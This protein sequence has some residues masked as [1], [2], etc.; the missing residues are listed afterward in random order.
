M[1]E[2]NANQYKNTLNL[3][4]TD[5]PMRG[6]LAKREPTM[7][8]Q[9][10]QL[11]LYGKL[12]KDRQDS[13]M[14][15]L[16]DGPPY[17]NGNIHIGHVV[18]KVIK[19]IIVKSRSMEGYNA[20]YVPGWDCHGLPIEHKVEQTLGKAGIDVEPA[21]F[22]KACREYAAGQID[23]QRDGFMR[24][25]IIGDWKHPYITMDYKIE[26]DI[27]R[28]LGRI[29]KQGHL[30][31]GE[32]PV[33]WCVDCGSALAEAEVEYED[34]SSPAIDVLFRIK[35]LKKLHE[36]CHTISETIENNVSI[37]IWTTTPWTLPA[38][39]AVAINPDFEYVFA[40]IEKEDQVQ[41]IIIAKDLLEPTL[42]RW[43]A[44]FRSILTQ[45]S[46]KQLEGLELSHP[47]LDRTV[48][49][50]L[51]DHVT[52]DT[53]TGAVH[54]AP[55][56]GLEDYLVGLRYGLS[57]KHSVGPDGHFL[58]DT[59]LF[60]G[61]QVFEANQHIIDI[62]KQRK[63]LM[64]ATTLQHSYPVCWRHKTPLIFRATPQWFISM[65]KHHLRD[66]ALSALETIQ[67]TPAWGKERLKGMILNRPDWCISRQR[68]WGVPLALFTHRKTGELHP[69]TETLIEKIA[70]RV[71]EQGVEAWFSLNPKELL[72]DDAD[73]YE[74]VTHILDVWFDS[75]TT[76]FSVLMRR[77]DLRFPADLYLEGSDQHRG[78]FQSSLLA[79]IGIN[80]S[81]PYK[82]VLTHGF[83]VDA[84]GRKMA[85]SLGN[86]IP[87]EK[88]INQLGADTIRLWVSSTDYRR[89]MTVS[90]QILKR[91]SEAY[92][93][94]RYTARYLLSNLHDF[95]PA[96]DLLA[97]DELLA[98]D[99][100]IIH[101]A[102]QLQDTIR[103]AYQRY[104]FHIIYQRIHNFCAVDLG[105]TYL[106]IIRDRQY[107]TQQNSR[108]R[109]SAQTAVYYITEALSRWLA[110]ILSFTADEIW[111]HIPG[112]RKESV[113]LEQWY[114]FPDQIQKGT[115][116]KEGMDTSFWTH[117]F[118][119]RQLVNRELEILR[120]E[121]RIG[122][123]LDAEVHLKTNGSTAHLLNLLQNELRFVLIT[124]EAKVVSDLSEGTEYTLEN[125][126]KIQIFAYPSSAEKCVRCWHHRADVGVNVNHPHLCG[127]CIDNIEG[128]GED[129][130]FA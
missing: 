14:F 26:A 83:T 108:A 4:H 7:L 82:G 56:H 60:A 73:N 117:I 126:E 37:V 28:A 24:L 94:I 69:Q 57:I 47:F 33:H 115:V 110:P 54:T 13:P 129:R 25:G 90:D 15:I 53:G 21:D 119:I 11:D 81:A 127:R 5:F 50:V 97:E 49:I 41:V 92:R 84:K 51:G 34:K 3:P 8:K 103:E 130:Q 74:K 64:Q 44:K 128:S 72:G 66:N 124:S 1:T 43:N 32:K 105:S 95:N 30:I 59:P 109:R 85:K 68:N 107:T 17:A 112:E 58:P 86:V 6:D 27:I 38:N 87:P 42:Q 45:C 9:W 125:G 12:R 120:K 48:P 40:E 114:M 70:Q 93:R 20:P 102:S 78:W 75:G 23:I 55:A 111:H 19:D 2:K 77:P 61:E 71:E 39:Q 104:D 91:T 89:E 101:Y 46:G 100:W 63:T 123:S 118:E 106:D 22:R 79:S 121:N 52:L 65:D 18:N 76:H 122:S 35:N 98:I 67:F 113:H 99:S 16:H 116:L 31:R 80:K 88:V 62:L 36:H 96:I 29:H 10:D